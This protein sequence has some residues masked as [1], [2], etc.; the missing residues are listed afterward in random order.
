MEKKNFNKSNIPFLTAVGGVV[1]FFVLCCL[2]NCFQNDFIIILPVFICILLMPL[3]ILGCPIGL[4]FQIL[5]KDK[6]KFDKVL[7]VLNSIC[8]V[9]MVL[10]IIF[11]FIAFPNARVGEKQVREQIEEEYTTLN[12][13][14]Q[15]VLDYLAKYK[16]EN[17]IYP[18]KID[19]KV[20]PNSKTFDEY[21]YNTNL[22][23]KGYWLQVYPIKGP[24]E[25]YYNDENDKGYNYYKGNDYIDGAFDNERYY[26][27][28]EMWH[29]IKLDY[30]TRHSFFFNGAHPEQETDEWM[31]NN[32]EKFEKNK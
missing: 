4:I 26:E 1:L 15:P 23:K 24:I 28:D 18:D 21:K 10:T 20:I 8:V 27:I 2:S 17:G 29:A 11:L 22:D 16:K 3:F 32:I 12:L 13:E 9:F 31:K 25:Y 30:F 5:H 14:Y 19:E 6:T 7:L